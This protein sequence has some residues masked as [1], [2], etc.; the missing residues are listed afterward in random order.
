MSRLGTILGA[1]WAVLDVVKTKKI[2]MLEVYGFLREWDDFCF[3]GSSRRFSGSTLGPSWGLVGH[4]DAILD[5][6]GATLGRLDALLDRL[7]ALFGSS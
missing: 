3:L 2:S 4:F 6:R 1:P 7:G 5:R